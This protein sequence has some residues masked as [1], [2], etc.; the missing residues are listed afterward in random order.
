MFPLGQHSIKWGM[1][2]FQHRA[3]SANLTTINPGLLHMH[4]HLRWVRGFFSTAT[5]WFLDKTVTNAENQKR[6]ICFKQ[7][8]A[9]QSLQA[10]NGKCQVRACGSRGCGTY[11]MY[12]WAPMC[13]VQPWRCFEFLSSDINENAFRKCHKNDKMECCALWSFPQPSAAQSGKAEIV[14]ASPNSACPDWVHSHI[15]DLTWVYL[16]PT[17]HKWDSVF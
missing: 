8:R 3:E 4:T 12:S 11:I 1:P 14:F 2:C 17:G 7:H 13:G 15:D 5:F 16:R 10:E 9:P 6:T